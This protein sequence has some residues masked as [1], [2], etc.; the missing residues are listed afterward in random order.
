MI[1]RYSGILS[2]A[3]I[4]SEANWM[5]AIFPPLQLY[6]QLPT[7]F[8]RLVPVLANHNHSGIDPRSSPMWLE[9]GHTNRTS[10]SQFM[11][12]SELNAFDASIRCRLRDSKPE[13]LAIRGTKKIFLLRESQR[14][15]LVMIE[16]E[17][18]QLNADQSLSH[19]RNPNLRYIGT[20]IQA[21]P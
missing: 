3:R 15:F 21:L 16:A 1:Y 10:R 17:Y 20:K 7:N 18:L 11:C 2:E 6:P 12:H 8:T 14:D 13:S 5:G 19:M 4:I 9:T